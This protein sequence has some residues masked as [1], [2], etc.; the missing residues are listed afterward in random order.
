MCVLFGGLEKELGE[1]N[2]SSTSRSLV[3]ESGDELRQSMSGAKAVI[4]KAT[5]NHKNVLFSAILGQAFV[6]VISTS[7]YLH[8]R[9]AGPL[10]L[11][12][13]RW[14]GSNAVEMLWGHID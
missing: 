8:G 11:F 5:H 12:N 10:R 4:E 2:P 9:L 14:Q 3:P 6:I 1:A 13:D 7:F